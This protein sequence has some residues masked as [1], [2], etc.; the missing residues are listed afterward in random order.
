[1]I[2]AKKKSFGVDWQIQYHLSILLTY[3]LSQM[4]DHVKLGL[5]KR[6]KTANSEL[7]LD[8]KEDNKREK[9]RQTDREGEICHA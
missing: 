3:E 1:M 6:K 7:P 9:G 2:V 8:I 5:E 4:T